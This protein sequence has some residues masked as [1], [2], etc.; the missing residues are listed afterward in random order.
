MSNQGLRQASVRAVTGTNESYEGDWH[1]LFDNAGI[2]TGDFNGRL[3]AW[4]NLKLS[5]SYAEL[6]GAMAALAAYANVPSWNEL[7]TFDASTGG[8]GG[9]TSGTPSGL[10]LVLTKA[11]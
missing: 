6:N 4:I 1:A 9:G 2:S 10:L 7:G 5:T 3:L 11:A 8:G